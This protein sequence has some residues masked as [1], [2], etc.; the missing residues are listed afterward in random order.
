[1]ILDFQG[2]IKKG[3]LS[4]G[5]WNEFLVAN[6]RF[7][8]FS[9]PFFPFLHYVCAVFLCFRCFQEGCF[10]GWILYD[11]IERSIRKRRR[12]IQARCGRGGKQRRKNPKGMRIS[13]RIV[14]VDDDR[15][16]SVVRYQEGRASK[17][18]DRSLRSMD[19]P[20]LDRLDA[21][22]DALTERIGKEE[23]C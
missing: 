9:F 5:K 7:F 14:V 3:R 1:M 4:T 10:S 12:K 19:F 15:S 18:F 20:S 13:M 22:T 21:T 2:W 17:C 11:E 8:F 16:F 23:I 6:H